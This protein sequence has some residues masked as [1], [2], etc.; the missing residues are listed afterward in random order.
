MPDEDDFDQYAKRVSNDHYLHWLAVFAVGGWAW[1]VHSF[2]AALASITVILIG[3]LV[4]NTIILAT[5]VSLKAVKINRWFWVWAVFA[6]VVAMSV[7][8]G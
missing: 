8:I 7:T 3:V 1:Q 6:V 2:L 5:T 4:G